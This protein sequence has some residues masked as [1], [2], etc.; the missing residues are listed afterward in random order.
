MPDIRIDFSNS[1]TR[2]ACVTCNTAEK[3]SRMFRPAH[4]LTHRCDDQ[5]RDVPFGLE[6]F[7][8]RHE[9]RYYD[10]QL[11]LPIRLV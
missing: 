4:E 6:E 5:M 9:G 2:S 8:D 3:W 10:V 1:M 7:M 11:P